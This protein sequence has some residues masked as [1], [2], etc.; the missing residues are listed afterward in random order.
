VTEAQA[1]KP[2][3]LGRAVAFGGLVVA[4]LVALV[5]AI[6]YGVLLEDQ[7][8]GPGLLPAVAGGLVALFAAGELAGTLRRY[9]S[10]DR[11]VRR[12]TTDGAPRTRRLLVVFGALFVAVLLVP[13]LGFLVAFFG[14]SLLV[15][16]VVERRPWLPSALVAL[17]SVAAIYAIFVLFLRVPLPGGLL[18]VGG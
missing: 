13:V 14:F 2:A 15:S 3:S 12:P 9:R 11:A 17:V 6:D 1:G 10:G 4:G 16:A 18:G 7:R 8:V 5:M